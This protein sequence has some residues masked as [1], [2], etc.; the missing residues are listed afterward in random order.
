MT[1]GGLGRRADRQRK[2]HDRSGNNKVNHGRNKEREELTKLQHTL[3][4]HHQCGD[5]TEG[6]KSTAGIGGND[7]IDTG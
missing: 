7:Y 2:M 5:V 4:P 3:L 6:A 1:R